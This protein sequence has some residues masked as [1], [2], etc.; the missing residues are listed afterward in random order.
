ML[1]R[2]L[3]PELAVDPDCCCSTLIPNNLGT[4]NVW[5]NNGK[6]SSHRRRSD[7]RLFCIWTLIARCKGP[8]ADIHRM[9]P[10]NSRIDSQRNA[11]THTLPRKA[12]RRECACNL[13]VSGV[14]NIVKIWRNPYPTYHTF[15]LIE[16]SLIGACA[17][18]EHRSFTSLRIV[19]DWGFNFSH[20]GHYAFPAV[21]DREESVG[22]T[23][24]DSA[25][26]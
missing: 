7:L 2:K 11:G 4:A 26:G 14:I 8:I 25:L 21:P 16:L 15:S 6:L 5:L 23:T 12:G 3:R 10:D 19:P 13:S 18:Q 1:L 24:T 17:V 22:T 20:S 9:H